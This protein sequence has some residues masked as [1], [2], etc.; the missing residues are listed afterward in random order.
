MACS[1]AG[2]DDLMRLIGVAAVRH[3]SAA[4]HASGTTAGPGTPA[5]QCRRGPRATA[6]PHP[7]SRASSPVPRRRRARTAGSPHAGAEPSWRKLRAC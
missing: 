4:A 2:G 1:E 7:A 6:A 3:S 5:A